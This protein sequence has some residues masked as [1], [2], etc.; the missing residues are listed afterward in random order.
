MNFQT[1]KNPKVVPYYTKIKTASLDD[2]YE[3]YFDEEIVDWFNIRRKT[4]TLGNLRHKSARG[5]MA[6]VGNVEI[7]TKWRGLFIL[8][9]DVVVP[10]A[11]LIYVILK[12]CQMGKLRMKDANRHGCWE[13]IFLGF[14][15]SRISRHRWRSSLDLRS[16]HSRLI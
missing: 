7:E 13:Y 14:S 15:I 11:F 6:K 9:S 8:T 1:W 4:F 12:G 3:E 2:S 16:S 5:F 10:L